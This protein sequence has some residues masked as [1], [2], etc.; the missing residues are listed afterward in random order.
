MSAISCLLSAVSYQLLA[1]SYQLSAINCQLSA[2]SYQLSAVSY[3]LSAISCQLSVVSYTSLFFLYHFFIF[4][5][6]FSILI[7]YLMFLL[8]CDT[9]TLV[10]GWADLRPCLHSPSFLT[11]SLTWHSHRKR[12]LKVRNHQVIFRRLADKVERQCTNL[13]VTKYI[14]VWFK[15]I[16]WKE[17]GKNMWEDFT[18]VEYWGTKRSK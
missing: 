14:R 7:S 5:L 1:V 9:L 12:F 8:G 13:V 17:C 2:V 3:Q 6:S 11:F 16:Y 4:S 10:L 18:C 15:I